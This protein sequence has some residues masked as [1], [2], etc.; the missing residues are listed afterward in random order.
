MRTA[1][2]LKFSDVAKALAPFLAAAVAMVLV[3]VGVLHALPPHG[4]IATIVAGAAAGAAVYLA[5][6]LGGERLRLWSGVTALTRE[7]AAVAWAM[8]RR[9]QQ[10]RDPDASE[11]EA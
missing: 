2:H 7:V 11:A 3:T 5:T 8:R 10:P 4:H 6:L 1:L 9:P